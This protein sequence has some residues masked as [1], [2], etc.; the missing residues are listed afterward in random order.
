MREITGR[1]ATA[2][3]SEQEISCL[4]FIP[5]A[6]GV[7]LAFPPHVAHTQVSP[8]IASQ[9]AAVDNATPDSPVLKTPEQTKRAFDNCIRENTRTEF[10]TADTLLAR[11]TKAPCHFGGIAVFHGRGDELSGDLLQYDPQRQLIYWDIPLER[12]HNLFHGLEG[13]SAYDLQSQK[14]EAKTL[15]GD[16]KKEIKAAGSADY[17]LIPVYGEKNAAGTYQ[18]TNAFGAAREVVE[19]RGVR[20]SIAVSVGNKTI[21]YGERFRVA[22]IPMGREKAAELMPFLDLRLYWIGANPCGK[23]LFGGSAV[24][25]TLGGPI[26]SAPFDVKMLHNFVFAKL[27]AVRFVDRRDGSTVAISTDD[28]H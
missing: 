4:R 26:L 3:A 7:L 15:T 16:E 8:D 5:L 13:V 11:A 27:V 28:S 18:A 2:T 14:K 12:L 22:A 6:I 9:L 10:D 20:Y 24:R 21:G 1:K 23:C 25:G 17:L 19:V